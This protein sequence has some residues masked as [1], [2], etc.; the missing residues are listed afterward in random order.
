VIAEIETDKATI[1][2][3]AQAGGT[4][5]KFLAEP[6]D[7]VP[8]GAPIA[9]VGAEGEQ[10]PEEGA[11]PPA[12]EP[13]S[14]A[15]AEAVAAPP[16]SEAAPGKT[17]DK[18]EGEARPE[19]AEAQ[20]EAEGAEEPG[21]IKASPIARRIAE[22]RGI[23]LRRVK[24]TGPGGRIV[25][26]DVETFPVEEA[27]AAPVKEAA[28]A[29]S[30][31]LPQP[32]VG[33]VPS[34][35]DVE[36]IEISRLRKRIGQRMVESKLYVPHFYVTTAI[37]VTALLELRKQLNESIPDEARKISVNDL[38]VKG[39]ALALREYPNL[40]T[41][42]YG[43]RLVRH[44]RIHIGIAVALPG[45]GLMNVVA[46]DADKTAL[47]TMAVQNREM[48]ARAREGKVRAE[49]VEGSTFSVS[50]LGPY[51]VDHFAAII[52]PPEAAILAIG[53]ARKTPVVLEDDTVGVRMIM[54]ATIS[55]DHRVS[56]G[57]E[58]AEFLKLFKELLEN[59]M[60]L[61]M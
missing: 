59:P 30:V 1:E 14:Q 29:P 34:G 26:R 38:I 3:E 4:I 21:F 25:K 42:F 48:I 53:A 15:E 11:P 57:A 55:V 9:Y 41:H 47:G 60:R 56:D 13:P 46:R 35:P 22:E 24:G 44:K 19:Y 54:K 20:A 58:G 43:D 8:V 50:N 6:G 17:E 23:D 27:P 10:V 36:I 33:E 12:A 51:D 39:A 5:L 49:D 45:G 32:S 7:V 28:H 52:N 2:I 16:K 37:D 31:A 40:N 61:L 18:D